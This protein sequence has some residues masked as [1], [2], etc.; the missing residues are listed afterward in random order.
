MIIFFFTKIDIII[1]IHSI[2]L[3]KISWNQLK[4][5]LKK[6]KYFEL[7]S[8][9]LLE[10]KKLKRSTVPDY[11]MKQIRKILITMKLVA[12]RVDEIFSCL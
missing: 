8:Q 3:G 10:K 1:I 9:L 7:P 12:L 6:K 4:E 11:I 2:F 5:F